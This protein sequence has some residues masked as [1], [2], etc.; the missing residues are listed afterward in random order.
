MINGLNGRVLITGGSGTLGKTIVTWARKQNW[1]VQFTILSRSESRL[2]MM[3]QKFPEERYLIGDVRDY[4]RMFSVIS[5]HDGV[6]HAAALK[7]IPE[8][9]EVPS[10]CIQTN[11]LGSLNI[12][13]AAGLLGVPWV[14]GI[15]TDKACCAST[16]YGSSKLLMEGLLRQS[17]QTYPNTRYFGLRYG[18]VLTSTGSVIPLWASQHDQ[19]KPLT[20]TDQRMTRFWISPYGAV[21]IIERSYHELESGQ[22]YIPKMKSL[23][24]LEVLSS[25]F[26][27]DRWTEV[28]LRSSEKLHEDLVSTNEPV[29]EKIDH[30]ILTPTNTKGSELGK[31][32][33][34][35]RAPLLTRS[36]FDAIYH[37][38][39]EVDHA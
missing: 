3:K 11:V 34:S 35:Y 32:W 38:A 7:R 39:F 22:I 4:D 21:R 18:N 24:V 28:G 6:I 33:D 37:E 8:C 26:P 1:D 15:S 13:R 10:E 27:G 17:S 31:S 20:I 19:R 30:F 23:P 25:L 2:A 9:E 36:E 29:I 5:G 12:F 14:C 16:T